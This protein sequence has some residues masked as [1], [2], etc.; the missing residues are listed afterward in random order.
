MGRDPH[1][2]RTPFESQV[3][4]QNAEAEKESRDLRAAVSASQDDDMMD[5][6]LN[7]SVSL[8][9]KTASL[10]TSQERYM[11]MTS[12][13]RYMASLATSHDRYLAVT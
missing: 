8:A 7:R 11:Y 10:A 13:Y 6:A 2:A 3:S 9:V 12:H 4:L 1:M 5:Y